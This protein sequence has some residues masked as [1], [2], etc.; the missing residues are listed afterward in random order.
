MMSVKKPQFSLTVDD[1]DSDR[2]SPVPSLNQTFEKMHM[3]HGSLT[4]GASTPTS[5]HGSSGA[6][7]EEQPTG[8][9]PRVQSPIRED[10]HIDPSL[11][12]HRVRASGAKNFEMI[13][14]P[15]SRIPSHDDDELHHIE[16]VFTPHKTTGSPKTPRASASFHIQPPHHLSNLSQSSVASSSPASSIDGEGA[17]EHTRRPTYSRS[18]SGYLSSESLNGD[19]ANP[20]SRTRRTPQA[21]SL[22]DIPAQFIFK[23]TNHAH[24]GKHGSFTSLRS[25]L[26]KE[27]N[28]HDKHDKHDKHEKHEKH[29]HHGSSLDLKRFF[30]SHQKSEKKDLS[31]SKSY[32]NLR[33]DQH[34]T[35]QRK[36]GK[37]GKILGTGAGG[38]VRIMKRSADG[39][40][41]A[42][43]EFR[44]RR[45]S[46]S[47]REY[48]RK[49]TAEFCIGSALHHTNIIET[50]DIIEEGKKFYEVM[51]YAPYDMF[52]IVMSGKMSSMEVYCCFRQLLAGVA[53][54][55]SM[56]L[57]HRDLKLDNLVMDDHW[58]V[59][60]IDFGS[61]AVFKYPFEA[62][63]VEASGVVG[64]DP[65]LAPETLVRKTY[66]PRAV[67]IWSCA[68]IFCCFALRRFPWKIPKMTDP[69][70][71]LF[72]AKS[73]ADAHYLE[74]LA[75]ESKTQHVIEHGSAIPSTSSSS[76]VRAQQHPQNSPSTPHVSANSTEHHAKKE[77][78]GPWRLLRLLPRES[79]PVVSHMLD[80]NPKSRYGIHQTLADPFISQI[81]WCHMENHKV[82]H[83]P[84]HKHTLVEPD[85]ILNTIHKPPK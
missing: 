70:F 85:S 45:P 27:H 2:N 15:P 35:L 20:Y 8:P 51:E 42:V 43:K 60:I 66:D 57:A 58:F 30:K 72:C 34:N 71:R 54:L 75:Q 65:Y 14:L 62:D 69:S 24:K 46:E 28:K 29:D 25:L 38:S 83:P 39:K 9:Y 78:F 3:S 59:K 33:E 77:V 11:I 41:F 53:Y 22:S 4:S 82:L 47:E 5:P 13:S 23:K 40:V 84:N 17:H 26:P 81:Q 64:S 1:D 18:T 48:A 73:P 52:S 7:D 44:A 68:I 76:P 36:Y 79:R 50:L 6:E 37:F 16:D 19:P 21:Q 55:H 31:K 61:A 80:L 49:V 10:N 56:G 67:D 63:I 12:E 74:D 32:A